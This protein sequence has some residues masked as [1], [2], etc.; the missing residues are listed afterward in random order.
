MTEDRI[1]GWHHQLIES[2]Q[3]LGDYE[4]RAAV[5]QSVGSQKVK[6]D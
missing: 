2:E 4:H 5:L 1:V 3:A 6:H